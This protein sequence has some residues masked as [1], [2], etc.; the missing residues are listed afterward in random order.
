MAVGCEYVVFFFECIDG[1]RHVNEY[2][3]IV[4]RMQ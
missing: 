1:T 3:S 2:F 4:S